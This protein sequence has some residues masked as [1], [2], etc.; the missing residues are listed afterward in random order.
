MI[1]GKREPIDLTGYYGSAARGIIFTGGQ[2]GNPAAAQAREDSGLILPGHPHGPE[3]VR[4]LFSCTPRLTVRQA[5]HDAVR[6]MPPE[7][8][9]EFF[10]TDIRGK[11]RKMAAMVMPVPDQDAPLLSYSLYPEFESVSLRRIITA[12]EGPDRG[13]GVGSRLLLS[14]LP[15]WAA[16]GVRHID[17]HTHTAGE[18]FYRKLGFEDIDVLPEVPELSA[19]DF[20]LL[21]LTL[22]DP[23]RGPS[24]FAAMKKALALQDSDENAQVR[25]RGVNLVPES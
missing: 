11:N 23:R 2:D 10:Y 13:R 16:A 17:L 19:N 6:H 25:L 5:F 3:S 18:G 15:F 24:F 12:R 20:I 7:S 4:A 22:D 21:R 14:Q 1:S 8:R 9:V